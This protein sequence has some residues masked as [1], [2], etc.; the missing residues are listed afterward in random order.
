MNLPKFIFVREKLSHGKDVAGNFDK[1]NTVAFIRFQDETKYSLTD[2]IFT[3]TK[4]ID[5]S[6]HWSLI[7]LQESCYK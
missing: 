5:K 1:H 3:D 2:L 6:K 4:I 7:L